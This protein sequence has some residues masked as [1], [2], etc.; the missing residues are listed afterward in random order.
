MVYATSTIIEIRN[1][2]ESTLLISAEVAALKATWAMPIRISLEFT[3]PHPSEEEA[4]QLAEDQLEGS[5][6]RSVLYNL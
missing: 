2:Y 3:W 4:R 6:E 1:N 5:D